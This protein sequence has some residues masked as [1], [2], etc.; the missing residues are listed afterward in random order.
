[1]KSSIDNIPV[2]INEMNFLAGISMSASKSRGDSVFSKKQGQ[3]Y[4]KTA[5]LKLVE[6]GKQKSARGI[7]MLAEGCSFQGRM[8]L[9]GESR[10]GGVIEGNVYS[11][12]F[13][14]IE[15]SAKIT[16]EVNGI[17]IVLN[18]EVKGIIKAQ[19]VLHITATARVS[20]EVFAKRLIVDDGGKIEGT[21]G[22]F[23][24]QVTEGNGVSDSN[25]HQQKTKEKSKEAV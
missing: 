19:D 23:K 11:D 25:I 5:N 13:L 2:E 16:G 9:Q 21:V 15:A 14:T 20:G 4:E 3:G 22:A 7:S 10:V 12:G 24:E 18:G 8:F 17:S 1:M 6:G